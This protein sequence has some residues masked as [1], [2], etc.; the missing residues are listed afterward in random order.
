MVYLYISVFIYSVLGLFF[1][2]LSFV[3]EGMFWNIFDS[4]MAYEIE[5]RI[6]ALDRFGIVIYLLY[7]LGEY[8]VV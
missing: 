4:N 8:L 3:L 6:L 2:Y 7:N 1:K 5:N